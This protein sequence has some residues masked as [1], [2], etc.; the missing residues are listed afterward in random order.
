MAGRGERLQR[1][2]LEILPWQ[3][4]VVLGK[5]KLTLR[6]EN[7]GQGKASTTTEV[8]W[9]LG[10]CFWGHDEMV[11]ENSQHAFITDGS[12]CVGRLTLVETWLHLGIRGRWWIMFSSVWKRLLALPQC[13]PCWGFVVGWL[14]QVGNQK[15]KALFGWWGSEIMFSAIYSLFSGDS[16]KWRRI[17]GVRRFCSFNSSRWRQAVIL[18]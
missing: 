5:S 11:T 2:N 12:C 15:G 6:L 4:G 16:S 9:G 13:Y 1:R 17:C 10:M 18:E 8:V 14:C 7:R 3:A